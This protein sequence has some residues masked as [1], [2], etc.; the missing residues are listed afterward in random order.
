[1][2]R[3]PETRLHR[4]RGRRWLM[5]A[6]LIVAL[7]ATRGWTLPWFGRW[8]VVGRVPKKTDV[9]LVLPGDYNTRPFVAA[10]LYRGGHVRRVLVPQAK[11]SPEELDG[12]VAPDHDTLRRIL[13]LRGVPREAIVVLPGASLSTFT[14]AQALARYLDEHPGQTVTAVTN[15]YHTRRTRWV[16]RLVLGDRAEPHMVSAPSDEHRP[17]SWWQTPQGLLA[18]S[19]EYAKMAYYQLK[20]GWGWAWVVA[21]LASAVAFW[22]LRRARAVAT[23]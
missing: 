21:G 1:M 7:Y 2:S 5:V 15:D 20:Y 8:L 13:E 10:A 3:S 17:D 9:C 12:Y 16:L 22:R 18:Y 4:R 19:S 11:P 6:G 23:A 14:D